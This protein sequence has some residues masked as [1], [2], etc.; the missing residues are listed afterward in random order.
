MPL[1]LS[2][3]PGLASL[4]HFVCCHRVRGRA[5]CVSKTVSYCSF[6]MGPAS[7]VP[8]G[9]AGTNSAPGGITESG[10]GMPGY[11]GGSIARNR[12]ER[13]FML[14]HARLLILRLQAARHLQ[15][16]PIVDA[17][18]LS[19]SA[20]VRKALEPSRRPS[21]SLR[22]LEFPAPIF[23]RRKGWR[24]AVRTACAQLHSQLGN[25]RTDLSCTCVCKNDACVCARLWR[26][27][28]DCARR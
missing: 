25:R 20:T 9:I 3:R 2:S 1:F 26:R 18:L 10:F 4:N 8:M 19:C 27:T 28:N 15:L 16:R 6:G 24:T 11:A 23:L 21:L 14:E 5:Q 22:R 17:I 7:G 13:S 12:I